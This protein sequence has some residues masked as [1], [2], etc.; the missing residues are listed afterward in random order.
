MQGFFSSSSSCWVGK[1]ESSLRIILN[2]RLHWFHLW[3]STFKGDIRF[4]GMNRIQVRE[5][6]KAVS[7]LLLKQ[8]LSCF[9]LWISPQLICFRLFPGLLAVPHNLE[10]SSSEGRPLLPGSR[11]SPCWESWITCTCSLPSI[12]PSKRVSF[13]VM[14]ASEVPFFSRASSSVRS[15]CSQHS[16]SWCFL[17][18]FRTQ[19]AVPWLFLVSG[20]ALTQEHLLSVAIWS[21]CCSTRGSE[22]HNNQAPAAGPSFEFRLPEGWCSYVAPITRGPHHLLRRKQRVADACQAIPNLGEF[23]CFCCPP[24]A[25]FNWIFPV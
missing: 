4:S 20:A 14:H 7:P 12:F 19:C 21:E 2:L 18:W 23:V 16:L 6:K 17:P 3:V 15:A 5:V 22:W 9:W 8:F 10:C 11:L 24:L 1:G 25:H 13:E